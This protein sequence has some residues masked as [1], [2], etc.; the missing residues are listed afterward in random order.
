[1]EK[2]LFSELAVA[3]ALLIDGRSL[4]AVR[5][6]LR[7][8][9]FASADCAAVFR[10]ACRLSDG[11]AAL[12]PVT[13]QADARAHGDGLPTQF[14]ANLMETTPTAAN[15]AQYAELVRAASIRRA[16]RDTA[17]ALL[18]RVEDDEVTTSSLLASAM[19]QLDNI[20]AGV[21]GAVI[22]PEEQAL[23]FLEWREKVETG[24]VVPAVSSGYQK[25]DQVLGGGFVRG[26]LYILAA[27]PGMGKTT[28]GLQIADRVSRSVRVLFISLEMDEQQLSS[29]RASNYT[30]MP[31]VKIMNSRYIS[32]EERE[33]VAAAATHID[34][35]GL[36]LNSPPSM[37]VDDIG[38]AARSIPKLGL[39]VI[40]YLGLVKSEG[41]SRSIYERTTETSN[42]LKRL[43][44]SLGIPILCL[45]QLNRESEHRQDKTPSIADLRDSGAIEQDADGVMLIYRPAVQGD[46]RN[47]TEAEVFEVNVAKNR[48]GKTGRV[49]LTYY[50]RN[51][52]IRE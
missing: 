20:S 22:T 10:A 34:S 11:G 29:R 30:A 47:E 21:H 35:T 23:H 17:T 51:G 28:L 1:M 40:D 4:A 27:R 9:D 36:Y 14:L 37:S 7:A 25:L 26:G 13:I 16:V 43:A 38:V 49:N 45:A 19:E 5:P 8:G 24:E 41:R 3:G 44:R 18:E 42:A 46:N 52:R 33:R 15:A 6:I 48:H 39:L 32:E 50:P 12:D 2:T 31:A